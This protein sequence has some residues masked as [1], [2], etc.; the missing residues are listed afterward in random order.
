[1]LVKNYQDEDD[2]S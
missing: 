2:Q 1:M